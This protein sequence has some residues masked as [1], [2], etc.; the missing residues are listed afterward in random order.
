M[1]QLSP[2]RVSQP[3]PDGKR[4]P[5]HRDFSSDNIRFLL[6]FLVVLGHMLERAAPFSLKTPIYDT[7]YS[8]HIPALIFLFGYYAKFSFK[9]IMIR[10]CIPYL[11]F[12]TLYILFAKY[13]LNQNIALQY[14]TPYWLLWYLLSCIFYQ[15]LM[16]VYKAPFQYWPVLML[17]C[18]VAL[19][20]LV[21][22]HNSIGYFLSLSRFF[23]FQ[24]WFLLGL[25]CRKYAVFE[26][27]S[28]AAK[29][30]TVISIVSIVF[31]GL[32][33][34]FLCEIGVPARL[35]YG[36][37][38][39]ARTHCTIWTRAITMLIAL[40]WIV[41][42]FVTLKPLLNKR[43]PVLTVIG[44]NTLPVFLLHGFIA[45]AIPV[46]CPEVLNSPVYVFLL[47]CAI[48]V[49]LGNHFCKKAVDYIGLYWLEKIINRKICD[50]THINHL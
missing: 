19:A 22:Y 8:F 33:M 47:A 10:W 36:S 5:S 46:F 6:I 34:W 43:L 28:T 3:M 30:R 50:E 39:Y 4:A 21:G 44:Q 15:L 16:P 29:L 25:Y 40:N 48:V 14:T 24:P 12:Q 37:Y 11:V 7:I 20:L 18:S 32:S 9:R 35:L 13:V 27:L 26:R 38:S 41:I 2:T 23:V 1:E 49:L 42:L 45:R 31:L 17:F